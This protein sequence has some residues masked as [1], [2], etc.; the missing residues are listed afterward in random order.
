MKPYF[1][2]DGITIYHG[3]AVDV[4]PQLAP[5]DLVLTDPPYGVA[6]QSNWGTGR[7]NAPITNDGTRLSLALYRQVIPLLKAE[8]VLWFTRWDAWP[9][10]WA[11]LGQWFPL[12]GL[13]VWDKNSPGMGD[14]NHWGLSYE[15]VASAG[16]RSIVGGRD[17]SILR[18]APMPP[19]N[20]RHPTEKPIDLMAYLIRKLDA[21]TVLD[22][23]CGSGCVLEAARL[24]GRKAIG[25][26]VKEAYCESAARRFDQQALPLAV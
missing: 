14:L 2:R 16:S 7:G 20:R 4:L 8:H 10:V 25:V 13:L 5:V 21:G 23:F 18:F 24:L 6:Y 9:D 1:E 15:L 22:P 26:E 19:A 17:S 11:I 3:D 12:R